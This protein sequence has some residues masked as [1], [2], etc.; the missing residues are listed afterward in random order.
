[1]SR[2]EAA[3]ITKV[4]G[5]INKVLKI[6]SPKFS[7]PDTGLTAE[8]KELLKKREIARKARDWRESDA[9]RNKIISLGWLVKDTPSGTVLGKIPR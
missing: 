9:L 5:E 3:G 8:V 4:L 1:M 6:I 2:A 7:K